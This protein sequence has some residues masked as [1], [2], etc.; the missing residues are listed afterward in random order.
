MVEGYIEKSKRKKILLL[1][2]DLRM[3]SGVATMSK[4]IVIGTAH[5]YNWFQLGG[6]LKHPE[7]GKIIDVS[8]DVNQATNGFDSDVKVMPFEGYGNAG[9][10]RQLLRQEK[11][12]AIFIFT[13][14]RYWVWLFEI[15]REIRNKIPILWLNIWDD[16]PAPMYNK[17]F[18]NSVDC[19]MGISKQTVNINKLVLGDDAKNKVIKYVPHGINNKQFYNINKEHPLYPKL[20]EFREKTIPN[21]DIEFLAYFNS[22]NIHRK[23]PGDV[24]LSFKHFCDGIGEEAAKKVGLVMHTEASNPHGT[25]LKAVKEA[26]YPEGNIYFSTGKINTEQMNFMYNICDVTMLITSNEGWGLS[27]TESL[28]TGTMIIPNVTGGMQDQCRFVNEKGEWIDFDS[29]FPSNHRGTYKECGVWAEP[30]YPSNISLA[31]SP[32][33]PYIYDDRCDPNDVAAALNYVYGLP[34]DIR[35]ANGLAG[36]NWLL[37]D[38]AQMTADHMCKNV[39]EAIDTTFKQFKPRKRFDVFKADKPSSKKV[40]HAL[41][42]Y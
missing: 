9:I 3:H 30:V 40:T 23:R 33:T 17:D 34:K 20:V 2:D 8:G 19:L 27:L 38:E 7:I 12:D 15:E 29:D 22:R 5:K 35:E 42:G 39:I 11:P 37:S 21:K 4:D 26:I 31:G 6:A 32:G 24:I 1:S 41:T 10:V 36:R 16:Y 13:D 18:Y 25:D 14:P 28:M